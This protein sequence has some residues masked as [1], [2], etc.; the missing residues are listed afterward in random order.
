[1]RIKYLL[2]TLIVGVVAA[3]SLGVA[4]ALTVGEA[5]GTVVT[6]PTRDPGRGTAGDPAAEA[7]GRTTGGTSRRTGADGA[8]GN[9]QGEPEKLSQPDLIA[10]VTPSVVHLAG[11]SGG[12][13]GVVVDDDRGL[14]L[15]NAHVTAGQQGMRARVGDD[16]A[17]ESAVRLVAAAPCDDLAVVQLVSRPADL[18]AIKLGDSSRLRR[19]DHVTVLGYPASFEQTG[20]VLDQQVVANDGSVS[21]VNVVAAPDPGLPRYVSTIQ[22]QAPVNHGNSGGPLV[23]D[24]G[25][26]VGINSLGNDEAQGQFYSI[27]VNRVRQLLPDLL[28]GRSQANLGWELYPRSEVNLPEV[29]A[30]DPDLAGQGGAAFGQQVTERLDQEGVDG[31]YVW[32]TEAGSPAKA[33]NLVHGDLVT[34]IDGAPVRTVQDVCDLVLSKRPGESVVVEGVYLNSAADAAEVLTPWETEVAVG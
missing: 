17:S 24:Q 4:V 9:D 33:G 21:A 28:A 22:H 19:G 20:S 25:R 8:G 12:G 11:S 18:R 30:A 31:L 32:D 3:A 23:D 6:G 34:S 29:F 7:G 16:P 5:G 1:M 26:L 15:T 14:V 2:A 10:K 13:S 27:S